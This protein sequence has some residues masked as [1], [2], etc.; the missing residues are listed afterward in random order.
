MMNVSTSVHRA[1][2]IS[3]EA[4]SSEDFS[5]IDIYV[6]TED[7]QFRLTVH[8]LTMDDLRNA[9]EGKS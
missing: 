7:G 3:F 9:L 6:K 1:K 2:S 5:W 4:K 8:D